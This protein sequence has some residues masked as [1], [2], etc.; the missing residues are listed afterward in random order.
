M[1]KLKS[2]K[3]EIVKGE[4]SIGEVR[5]LFEDVDALEHVYSNL[6]AQDKQRVDESPLSLP[7]LADAYLKHCLQTVAESPRLPTRSEWNLANKRAAALKL[8]EDNPTRIQMLQ[9]IDEAERKQNNI[10]NPNAHSGLKR[11]FLKWLEDNARTLSPFDQW[12]NSVA[13]YANMSPAQCLQLPYK[14]FIT[15]SNS[16]TIETEQKHVMQQEREKQDAL[17]H[18]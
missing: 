16:Y 4:L 2:D 15:L 10:S 9:E 1:I 6:N 8:A 14:A 17:R 3:L 13:A 11:N 18:N 7:T 12:V 5:W